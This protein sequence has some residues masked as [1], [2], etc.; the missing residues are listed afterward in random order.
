MIGK[1]LPASARCAVRLGDLYIVGE[2]R[3]VSHRIDALGD[4]RTEAPHSRRARRRLVA[5]PDRLRHI[6]VAYLPRPQR[7]GRRTGRNSVHARRC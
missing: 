2:K 7:E 4:W 6:L 3:R 1:P 5:T